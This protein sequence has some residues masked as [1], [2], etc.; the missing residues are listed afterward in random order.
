MV[1]NKLKAAT[2]S[3]VLRSIKSFW[4][5]CIQLYFHVDATPDP[6][7][8]RQPNSVSPL[9][10]SPSISQYWT[11]RAPVSMNRQKFCNLQFETVR[12]E[13]PLLFIRHQPPSVKS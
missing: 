4:L 2:M 3:D 5:S 11:V 7:N 12:F 8:A 6:R 10:P 9:A 13:W 1:S